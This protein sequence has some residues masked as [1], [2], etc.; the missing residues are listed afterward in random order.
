MIMQFNDTFYLGNE[1]L[2][3]ASDLNAKRK[4]QSTVSIYYISH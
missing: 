3:A 2:Y 4:E 1:F